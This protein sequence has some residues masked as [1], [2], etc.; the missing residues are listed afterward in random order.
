MV[1]LVLAIV[2]WGYVIATQYPEKTNRFDSVE[3]KITG[4]P[5]D[6]IA[7][8]Y[9]AETV[10]VW[11]SGAKDK[12]DLVQFSAI[13][14]Q[15]DLTVCTKPG[16]CDVPVKLK[17]V[18]DNV[19]S[20]TIK[21]ETIQ[22]TMEEVVS[23]DLEVQ[24]DKIGTVRLGY[25]QDDIKLNP[26]IV[27]VRGPKS[28]VDQIDKAQ[29]RVNLDDRDSSLQGA[30]PVILLDARGQ[31]LTD[32]DKK[33]LKVTPTQVN[34]TVPITFKL[35]AKTVPIRVVT[36]GQPAPGYI[37]GSSITVDPSIV[38][39]NGDPNDLKPVEYVETQPIDLSGVT[40]N[41]STTVQ[42]RIPPNI[43]P[44]IKSVQVQIG[45]TI[46][47]ASVPVQVP[48]E[49]INPPAL[50]YDFKP[51]QATITLQGPY[52]LLQPKLPLDQ[53][54]ATVDLNGLGPGTYELPLKVQTPPGLVATSLPNIS[55]TILAP[56]R[57]TAIPIPPT[58]TPLPSPTSSAIPTTAP[59]P[60]PAAT[61]TAPALNPTKEPTSPATA[62]TPT[63]KP[64]AAANPSPGVSPV[65]P[66]SPK[67]NVPPGGMA[68]VTNAG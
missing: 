63:S 25:S 48:V 11:I 49:I 34:V 33:D 53:I 68:L 7:R 50:R 17:Q 28:L 24:I 51:T 66:A 29:V 58:P 26:D 32:L 21:P 8:Q 23:K 62:P 59:S 5:T 42:L 44:S 41:I 20:Y 37:A 10:T 56:P 36:T 52:Q 12:V 47:Q 16:T 22:V 14:P 57:P 39:L 61:P 46:A 30:L 15:I 18:P 6:L 67:A 2:V 54:K 35:N 65:T 55:V 38:T 31:P 40:S 43:A 19:S 64:A 4:L 9:S 13:Q 3:V 27:S 45:I 1:A 60:T